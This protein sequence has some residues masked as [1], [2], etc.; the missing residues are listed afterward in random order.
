MAAGATLLD[1]RTREEFAA[2][3]LDGAKN[4]PVQELAGRM[5]ELGPT[6]TPLVV[7]CHAGMR[8]RAAVQ[9]LQRAGYTAVFDLGPMAAW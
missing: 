8:S 7:Y 4:L 9:M 2:G 5:A 6:S 3:H 1:V